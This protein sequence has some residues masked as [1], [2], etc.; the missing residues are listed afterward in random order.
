MPETVMTTIAGSIAEIFKAVQCC[1]GG[2]MADD[3]W[4]F[5][6]EG[7]ELVVISALA[8]GADRMVAEAG[9]AVGARLE[10]VLP[11][12]RSDYETDFETIESKS[13]FHAFLDAAGSVFELDQPAGPYGRK[14][15]Y[16]A[17]GLIMLA[18]TDLLIAVWDEQEA[19]GIGGTARIVEQAVSEGAPVFLINPTEPDVVRLLWSGDMA[20]APGQA[21]VEDLPRRPGLPMMQTVLETLIEPPHEDRARA[22][23]RAFFREPT[24]R[25]RGAPYYTLFLGLFGVRAITRSDF[26]EPDAGDSGVGRWRAYFQRQAA[27][28]PLLEAVCDTLL[29]AVAGIDRAAVRYS[30][31]YRSAFVFNFIASALAVTFALLGLSTELCHALDEHVKLAI[32]A[33][34][35][36]VEMGLIWRIFTRWR[37]GENGQWH[38]RWLNYRRAAEWL[39]HLR[40][41][42]LVGGRSPIPRP[43]RVAPHP[44]DGKLGARLEHNDWVDW[45]I[46]SIER[47]LPLPRRATP[48]GYLAEVRHAV[49]DGELDEQVGYH[50]R[51]SHRMELMGHRLHANG[52]FLF[53]APVVVGFT[54]LAA[55]GLQL[56]LRCDVEPAGAFPAKG[57]YLCHIAE[58]IRFYITVLAAVFPAFGAALNAIRV[59]GDFETIAERSAATAARLTSVRT[60]METEAEQ[61]P[62]LAD[63]TQRAAEVMSIENAEWQTLSRTRPLSL[64]A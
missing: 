46:R 4:A 1:L 53:A 33:L 38:Q 50:H 55:F 9:Q 43:R 7:P 45:Y 52:R 12:P 15:G 6:R 37:Q 48:D 36:I 19:A 30:E 24:N 63:R 8:E 18:H 56:G 59:Q 61:F 32:K 23:L 42:T 39:R 26:R 60:A 25:T 21:R 2:A 58:N 40:I 29:P 47:M 54:Y 13:A 44:A 10:V 20:L 5:S 51:N 57:D 22:G 27:P 28:D 16:E 41:I 11:F 62:L 34:L 3:R 49:I 64:P 14:R 17:A 31:L 35:V